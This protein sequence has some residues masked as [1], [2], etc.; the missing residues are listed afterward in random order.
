MEFG[1]LGENAVLDRVP[2]LGKSVSMPSGVGPGADS[3]VV[4]DPYTGISLGVRPDSVE[5]CDVRL[6]VTA[7]GNDSGTQNTAA[8]FERE[9]R[10]VCVFRWAA[11]AATVPGP[12]LKSF[13]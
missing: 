13:S 11:L 4:A 5:I 10:V 8:V 7:F 12:E 1:P 3:A 6:T 2:D 9:D